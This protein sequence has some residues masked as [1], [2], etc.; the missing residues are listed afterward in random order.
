MKGAERISAFAP[1]GRSSPQ[2]AWYQG[3]A[4][5]ARLRLV[6]S[7]ACLLACM[8]GAADYLAYAVGEKARLPLPESL[9]G[10]D[11]KYLLN[12]EWG[13]YEG[14]RSR[15]AVLPVDNRSAAST[16]QLVATD[17]ESAV[18][19]D[20]ENAGMVPVNGVEAIVA[21][22]MNRTGR[23]RLLERAAL[24]SVIE[25]QDLATS[26]RVTEA[27]GARTG[28]VLGAQYLVQVVVTDYEAEVSGRKGGGLGGLLRDRAGVLGAVGLRSGLGRVGMNF[29]L[30]DAE[31]SEVVHTRQVE[32]VIRERGLT[33]G[34][35]GIGA[36]AA[37][38]GFFAGYA[39]TP[40]GQA[41]IA[42]ANK[43]VYEMVKEIGARPASGSV[44]RAEGGRIWTNL[45]RSAVAVGDVL[46]V[47]AKG[48]ELI[49]P[50]TGISLGSMDTTLGTARV[51]EVQD[52]FSVAE[53][54]SITG[55]VD[56]GDRIVSTAAP[57]G[58][59]FAPS[60]EP[61]RRGRF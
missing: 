8:S 38:G 50:E 26:E 41:V 40:V 6:A 7:A 16:L 29:R 20:A 15:V 30:I 37:L 3:C 17:G 21:D 55:D 13:S 51:A 57:P 1:W 22:V 10:I 5:V 31:T 23:F 42:G 45:G 53:A 25:E 49:D 33:V 18:A 27:S 56:R 54:V 4:T 58:I 35:L 61:P 34:G 19:I 14:G 28:N 47:V 59:E 36:G 11:A 46:E 44:V 48:E 43:G 60:W 9:E 52:R 39:R 32:S 24:E 2:A 12:L